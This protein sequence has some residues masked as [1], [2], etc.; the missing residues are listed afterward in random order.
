MDDAMNVNVGSPI[1]TTTAKTFVI[2]EFKLRSG[3]VMHGVE[4]SYR[5]RG[6]LASDGRNAVLI[7]HGY[8]SGPQMIEP[9]AGV[10]EGA[11]NEIV[12]PGKP[13]DTDRFFVV[14][15][16]MLGSSYGSTNAASINPSTRKRYAADFPEL[17]VSDIVASQDALLKSLGVTH[18]FAIVGPSYGGFQAFQW[19]VDYPDFMSAIVP[20]VT[21]P[22]AQRERSDVNVANLTATFG[23]NPNWHDGSYYDQGGVFDT[24]VDIRTATLKNYGIE[25]RLRETMSEPVAIEAAIREEASH[26]AR[27]FDANSLIIL[28]KAMGKLDV[29][30]RFREIKVPVL[31]ILSRTDK[32]F[33]PA[34]AIP[35]MK[36]FK[37]A[38]VAA[39]YFELDS[40]F[41]HS[42]SGK[43][44]HKWAPKLREFLSRISA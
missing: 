5:T 30:S 40:E 6:K 19:A 17:T 2:D 15:P 13:V 35:V 4:I 14:C 12:G 3:V 39:E 10:G 1:A 21:S 11:W 28:G 26:W 20:V 7:T 18:L 29:S 36:A 37:D 23:K 31:Y 25:A 41:G 34:L 32:L 44:A 8:T 43:D 33:P 42:A 9:S 38:G 24:L 27:E 22:M 16:N